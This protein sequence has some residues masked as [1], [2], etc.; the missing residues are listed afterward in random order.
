MRIQFTRI[1]NLHGENYHV[2]SC[3]R[4]ITRADSVFINRHKLYI[5]DVTYVLCKNKNNTYYVRIKIRENL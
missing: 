3:L 2:K 5:F 1:C 4:I